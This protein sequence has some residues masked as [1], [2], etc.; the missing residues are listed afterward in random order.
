MKNL[1]QLLTHNLLN[2]S[3]KLKEIDHWLSVMNRPQ[4]WHYDMDIVW[5]L[6]EL[7]NSGIKKG[8]TILDAGAGM[9]VT[10]FI[11]AAR[12]FNVI[13]LDFSHREYP[14]IADGIFD[15]SIPSNDT[16][17]YNHN[18]MGSVDYGT[19]SVA[20][21]VNEKKEGFISLAIKTILKGSTHTISTLRNLSKKRSNN[22]KNSNERELDH[23]D[24]GKIK[25]IR[26]A[27]HDIPIEDFSVDA[28]VS[29]SAIEHADQALMEKN[30]SEM[31]RILKK[32]APLLITTSATNQ[33]KDFYHKKTL[34]W[35]YSK[36]SLN[37]M[38]AI[39]NLD[40]FNYEVAEKEILESRLWR[41]RIDSYYANDPDSEFFKKRAK[42][43]PYL[44]VGIKIIK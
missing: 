12:G 6:Q 39:K 38:A 25:F 16:L 15:I 27:F 10:Q 21:K 1:V 29:V 43:L 40:K 9:G 31:K 28:I 5:L 23:S 34:G 44:P 24:F 26:A 30:I 32:G 19:K 35:C 2:D 7:E 36:E 13:S 41:S 20:D 17:N 4:G 8:D 18:Y 42:K 11:L 14:E 33:E 22:L 3:N 37:K